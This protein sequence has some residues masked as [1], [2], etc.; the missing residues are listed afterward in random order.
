MHKFNQYY[1]ASGQ[2][3]ASIRKTFAT[4]GV[5]LLSTSV[6]LATSFFVL[7]F[8]SFYHV[9]QF[10]LLAGS[11]TIIAFLADMLVAPALLMLT[12]DDKV[13]TD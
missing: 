5:A 6:A 1:E 9:V 11:A 4:T 10:G 3:Q 13:E 7:A 8:A 12:L 2:V